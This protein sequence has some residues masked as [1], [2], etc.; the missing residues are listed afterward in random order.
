MPSGPANV[1]TAGI[2]LAIPERFPGSRAWR[3]NAVVANIEGRVIR[4]GIKGQADITGILAPS[5]RRLEIEVKAGK[6]RMRPEQIAFRDAVM[7]AGG[8][9]V[10]AHSVEQALFDLS[11]QI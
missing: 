8:V 9:H 1:I 5:G 10:I 11:K 4:A 2:L 6:D 7:A 3:N